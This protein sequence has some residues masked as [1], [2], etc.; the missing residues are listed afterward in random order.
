MIVRGGLKGF[1]RIIWDRIF[2]DCLKFFFCFFYFKFPDANLGENQNLLQILL[3]KINRDMLFFT[4]NK[5]YF[6]NPP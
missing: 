3:I 4:F 1:I 5:I 6:H 2:S